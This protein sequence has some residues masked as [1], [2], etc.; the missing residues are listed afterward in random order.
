VAEFPPVTLLKPVHGIEPRLR[1][2]LE[3]FFLLDY[4]QFEIIFGA[5]TGDDPAKRASAIICTSDQHFAFDHSGSPE[6][7]TLTGTR[8]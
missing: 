6:A 2:N 1:D 7:T 3:S 8:G 5:R 4:P